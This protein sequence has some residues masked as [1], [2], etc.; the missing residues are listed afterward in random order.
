MSSSKKLLT[1]FGATG[2]QGGSVI[3]AV[4]GSSTL[5]SKYALRAITRDPSKPNAQSLASK[6]VELAK[7]DLNDLGSVAAAIKGS[8][9]VFAVTN[10][11]ETMSKDIEVQ[12]GHNIVDACKDEGV[13][14]LVW[15]ALPNA[16]A[17][18][19]GALKKIEHFDSKAEVASYAEK[20]KGEGLMVSYFMPAYFMSNLT[21]MVKEAED[22]SGYAMSLPWDA[23]KT[24]VGMIDIRTDTGKYV[25]GLFEA[26][27]GANG[28]YVN[29]VSDWVH[30]SQIAGEIS[31]V[32]GKDVK[33]VQ[34]PMTTDMT[35]KMDKIPA[36]LSENMMLIRDYSYYGLGM[37]KKQAESDEFFLKGEKK[38][39]WAGFASK[40]NFG[41]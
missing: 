41:I 26:G 2:N 39:K 17:I 4:L 21:G 18:T 32:T 31:K 24:W 20:I 27:A 8:Y 25:A 1:V 19:G 12:Q 3:S 40:A 34:T 38:V 14:H 22:G 11:W 9:G 10:Y 28:K 30:P 35:A 36:E 16:T 15:S 29:G 13:K 5:S 37:E 7:A 33:W 6:G 23:E